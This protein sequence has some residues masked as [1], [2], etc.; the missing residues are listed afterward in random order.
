MPLKKCAVGYKYILV[1][2][3]YA[4]K[5]PEAVPVCSMNSKAIAT[6]LM[7]LFARVGVHERF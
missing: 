2:I 4:I 1:I 7:K 6:E 5:Y 3:D